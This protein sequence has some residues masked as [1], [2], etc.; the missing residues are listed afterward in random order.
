MRQ[1]HQGSGDIQL[2][3]EDIQGRGAGRQ[4]DARMIPSSAFCLRLTIEG[5]EA[6]GLLPYDLLWP[7]LWPQHSA[8]PF[9]LEFLKS[10]RQD[11][12][13]SL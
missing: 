10:E 5:T 7:V 3:R 4:T 1:A 12:W 11:H 8:V 6:S 13:D 2:Q 9:R